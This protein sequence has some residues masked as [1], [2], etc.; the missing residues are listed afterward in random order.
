ME[1]PPLALKTIRATME[2]EE[3]E[4]ATEGDGRKK[5][6]GEGAHLE[7]SLWCKEREGKTHFSEE[8]EK[9]GE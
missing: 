2:K 9:E 5:E 6:E 8:A 1:R 3:E 7:R 4:D